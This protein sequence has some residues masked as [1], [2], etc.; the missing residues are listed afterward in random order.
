MWTCNKK[1]MII[2]PPFCES[3]SI[4]SRIN[5]LSSQC[6]FYGEK[7]LFSLYVMLREVNYITWMLAKV[8]LLF[9]QFKSNWLYYPIPLGLPCSMVISASS[10]PDSATLLISLLLY[11]RWPS[12]LSTLLCREI[13]LF[14][15]YLYWICLCISK[16]SLKLLLKQRKD[17]GIRVSHLGSK[18]GRSVALK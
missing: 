16:D 10:I 14:I 9:L 4:S 17:N 11:F 3:I 12:S 1:E 13:E 15:S 6:L 18:E 2:S 8:T 7:V 5:W